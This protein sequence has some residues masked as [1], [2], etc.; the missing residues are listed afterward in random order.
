MPFLSSMKTER[1]RMS[2]AGLGFS[3]LSGT[4]DRRKHGPPGRAFRIGST[5]EG[6]QARRHGSHRFPLFL[7]FDTDRVCPVDWSLSP[8]LLSPPQST[9]DADAAMTLT[10]PHKQG[11]SEWGPWWPARGKVYRCQHRLFTPRRVVAHHAMN[12]N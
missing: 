11:V 3:Q 9:F 7:F 5:A 4:T 6:A 12:N 10:C 8:V 1:C 2:M